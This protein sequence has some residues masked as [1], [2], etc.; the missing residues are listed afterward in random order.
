MQVLSGVSDVNDVDVSGGDSTV[1]MSELA[2]V[3][4]QSLDYGFD[5]SGEGEYSWTERQ[6]HI[7]SNE[8]KYGSDDAWCSLSKTHATR[9]INVRDLS[10]FVLGWN[11]ENIDNQAPSI[12]PVVKQV[13]K[14]K[15]GRSETFELPAP[16][17]NCRMRQATLTR[18]PWVYQIE[19]ESGPNRSS[20]HT[21]K[22]TRWVLS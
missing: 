17:C 13:R 10:P 21:V 11:K 5:Q 7:V 1:A 8:S 12:R 18:K 9:A 6:A 2:A 20:G 3:R 14:E 4:E 22:R 16:F 15:K 19:A